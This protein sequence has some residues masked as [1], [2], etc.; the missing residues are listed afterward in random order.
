MARVP[1]SDRDLRLQAQSHA[2]GERAEAGTENRGAVIQLARTFSW[3]MLTSMFLGRDIAIAMEIDRML[4]DFDDTP[5]EI[6]IT[7]I[8][9]DKTHN[10]A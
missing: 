7:F 1:A 6:Q 3:R 10:G 2:S 4:A 9:Y 5:D 8:K